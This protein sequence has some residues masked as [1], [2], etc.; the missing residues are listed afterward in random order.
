MMVDIFDVEQ[1]QCAIVTAP[2]GCIAMVDC[3]HNATT[4]WR[5]SRYVP[6]TLQRRHIDYLFVT[7]AD[8]DHYSDL[9]ELL[10]EVT[11]G[12][13]HRNWRTTPEQ[14]R[15]LKLAQAGELSLD[16]ERYLTLHRDFV[17]DL[18][19]TFDE[20]MGGITHAAFCNSYDTF[21]NSTNNLSMVTFMRFGNFQICFPGDLERPGW[22]ELLKAPMFR[23]ELQRTT[24][25]VA[26]H[27]GRQ[28]GYCNDVFDYCRPDVVVISDK[29]HM[30]DTQV[31]AA[32]YGSKVRGD[33]IN[34]AMQAGKRKVLSTRNDG[35]IRFVVEANQYFVGVGQL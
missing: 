9:D 30:H 1:G 34:V 25:L 28:S 22:L 18:G 2:N 11:V 12:R 13:F 31:S 21:W 20:G 32:L 35:C 16:A 8:E 3:G 26:P 27:H 17:H 24:V 23:A 19:P 6:N 14:L 5:P 7:N 29:A 4:G 10:A 33:G 15:R